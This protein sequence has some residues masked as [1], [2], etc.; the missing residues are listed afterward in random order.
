MLSDHTPK[1][2]SVLP[3]AWLPDDFV[4]P[5]RVDLDPAHHLRP[6]TAA[7]VE[8]DLPAVM[9]SRER[10]FSIFGPAW[11]WPP[12]SMTLEQDREDLARHEREIAEHR[13]FNYAVFD[14]GETALLGCIYL[15]PAERAGADAD[16]SWWVVDDVV[17]TA[18]E[19][20]LDDFVP[21]WV[22]DAW[23]FSGPRFIGRDLTWEAWLALPEAR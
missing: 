5:E 12:V 16:V 1:S 21:R 7:D 20:S 22:A 4:H 6:I 8:L 18:V 17:G 23:P 2:G 10:L 9:G 14:E 13:S 15:D 3:V 11:G 19:R